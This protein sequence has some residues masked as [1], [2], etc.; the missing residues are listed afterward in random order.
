M[1]LISPVK[2]ITKETYTSHMELELVNPGIRWVSEEGILQIRD[3]YWSGTYKGTLGRKGTY[4]GWVSVSI[5]LKTGEGTLS[6][7]WLITITKGR[8]QGTLAGS[9]RGKITMPL[10]SGTFVGTHG[11]GE[12]EGVQI[13]GLW[14]GFHPDL[15]HV[16]VEAEG[17]I[18]YP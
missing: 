6:E 8:S 15:T 7:N 10:I 9:N 5:N 11:T 17:T 3:S 1:V 18:K 2:T 14:E 13:M 12:F 16:V 4:E